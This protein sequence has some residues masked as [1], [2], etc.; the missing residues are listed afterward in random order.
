MGAAP[1]T[2][3][4]RES[5]PEAVLALL[6]RINTI[7]DPFSAEFDDLDLGNWPQIYVYN[8]DPETSSS[9]TP[10]FMEAFLEL[11]KQIYQLAAQASVGVADISQISDGVRS[12]LE[13]S[14][15]VA[16]GSSKLTA[17]LEKVLPGLL[18]TMIR[19]MDGKQTA[20]VLVC[21]GVLVAADWGF[22]SWLEYKIAAQIEELKSK[23]HVEALKALSLGAAGQIE[24]PKKIIG[25][26]EKQGDLGSRAID[27]ITATNE[28]L[29]KAASKTK[30]ALSTAP[31]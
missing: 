13:I 4:L 24:V 27:A 18:K 26:L 30:E 7:D 11:Q 14:V 19:K 23:E 5:A 21:L 3:T 29:L 10:P 12:G 25:V 6:D 17:R 15:A 16:D 20:I 8:P 2:I 9:I 1:V 31:I 28:A 22:T